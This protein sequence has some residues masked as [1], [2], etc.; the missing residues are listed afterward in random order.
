MSGTVTVATQF[1]NAVTATGAQLDANFGTI[2]AYI[3]DP[4]N[5]NNFSGDGA[6]TNTVVLTFSPPVVGGYTAGLGLTWKWGQTNTGATVINANGLGNIN[7]VNQ[8]GSAL[9]AGQGQAGGI[10]AAVYDGTRAIY[11]VPPAP[12]SVA[13]MQ[14]TATVAAFVSPQRQAQ[15]PLHP[16]AATVWNGT[17]T[18]TI[19]PV[20]AHNVA[21]V[22]K[23]SA[24]NY[25]VNLIT[26]MT[27]TI[28]PCAV[29]AHDAGSVTSRV[30]STNASQVVVITTNSAF[31]A[32]DA[33]FVSV[34]VFGAQS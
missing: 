4:T 30:S 13:Q 7:L 26:P 21:N 6:A 18:G 3:N 33:S 28:F 27:A 22:V 11:L 24:G 29:T 20:Y 16:K 34:H 17:S 19:T 1:A 9:A 31:N 8:D 12:A 5:R 32:A 2:C 15:H 10:G 14:A 25:T 23:N